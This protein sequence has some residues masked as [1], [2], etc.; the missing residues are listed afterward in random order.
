[1]A[2]TLWGLRLADLLV[3]VIGARAREPRPVHRPGLRELHPKAPGGDVTRGQALERLGELAGLNH[4]KFN[5]PVVISVALEKTRSD[6][7]LHEEV[8][9]CI[10]V[11]CGF[12]MGTYA[13]PGEVPD[14]FP[15]FVA[16][17]R[18]A[19]DEKPVPAL[20]QVWD[21]LTVGDARGRYVVRERMGPGRFVLRRLHHAEN[22]PEEY[23]A[24]NEFA[25]DAWVFVGTV[26]T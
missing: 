19:F 20:G 8:L 14:L 25:D 5:V 6:L 18:W 9:D 13:L 12:P 21:Y 22:G 15:A 17:E 11:I 1:M 26:L 3:L 23:K 2:G 10:G 7:G 16:T 4:S 24:A